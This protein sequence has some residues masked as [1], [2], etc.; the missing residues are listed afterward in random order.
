MCFKESNPHNVDYSTKLQPQCLI[1]VESKAVIS[2]LGQ[3]LRIGV[4][5]FNHLIT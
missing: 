2:S 1:A 5:L 3:M 4:I